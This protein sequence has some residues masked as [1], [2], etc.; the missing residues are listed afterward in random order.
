MNIG[1]KVFLLRR[2]AL[3]EYPNFEDVVETTI[4]DL[5]LNT[6]TV[7][8]FDLEFSRSSMI[9]YSNYLTPSQYKCILERRE[10]DDMKKKDLVETLI[11]EKINGIQIK[12]H[13]LSELIDINNKL[14]NLYD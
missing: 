4:T 10:I 1:D 11:R 2:G 12:K 14:N 6:F 3:V 8:Y 9:N 13:S 5:R 7:D